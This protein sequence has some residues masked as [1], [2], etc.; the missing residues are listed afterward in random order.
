M[1]KVLFG[2]ALA[3]ATT[4]T[5]AAGA[6]AEGLSEGAPLGAY[7]VTKIAGADDDGVE[8][9]QTLCYR[10]R[11]GMSPMVLVFARE[12][13][14]KF[15]TLVKEL[16]AAVEGNK[17][18]KLK[19]VI[20]LLGDDKKALKSAGSKLAMKGNAKNVPIAYLKDESEIRSY[21]IGAK[22]GVTVVVATDGQVVSSHATSADKID[23]AGLMKEIKQVLN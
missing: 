5:F 7:H 9:D 12:T 18:A 6:Q 4:L 3:L 17:S 13:D 21:K 19:T 23:I 11:Y 8:A 14:G 2:F 20:T 16:N 22:A 1:T 15:T 10:C